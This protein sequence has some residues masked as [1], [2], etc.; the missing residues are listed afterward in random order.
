MS[1]GVRLRAPGR[2]P[3]TAA[4]RKG[5]ALRGSREHVQGGGRSRSAVAGVHSIIGDAGRDIG[6]RFCRDRVNFAV[7]RV[8][9]FVVSKLVPKIVGAFYNR[10][11][12]TEVFC[13]YSV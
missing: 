10:F 1:S 4:C 12:Y 2:S 3:S 6:V 13:A 11:F 9:R 5:T 7:W 8:Y